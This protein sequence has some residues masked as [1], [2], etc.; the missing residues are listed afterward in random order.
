MTQPA[1]GQKAKRGDEMG[2]QQDH[3]AEGLTPLGDVCGQL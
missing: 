3:C 2:P 1:E